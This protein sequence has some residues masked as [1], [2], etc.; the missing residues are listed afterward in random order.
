MD[1]DKFK[2]DCRPAQATFQAT[3]IPEAIVFDEFVHS[4]GLIDQDQKIAVLLES[5]TRFGE[6]FIKAYKKQQQDRQSSKILEHAESRS[7]PQDEPRSTRELVVFPF[8]M[9]IS[10]VRL[11]YQKAGEGKGDGA[12]LPTFGSKL[13]MPPDEGES[14]DTEPSLQAGMT[15]VQ[16][17]RMLAGI[18]SAIAHEGFRYVVITASDVR[19]KIFLATL[20]RQ[21]CPDVR[22]LFTS[23]EGLLSHPNFSPYLKGAL[24]AGTYPLY[25]KNQEWSFPYSQAKRRLMFSSQSQQG[26]YNAVLALLFPQDGKNFLEYGPPF[27]PPEQ[28]VRPPIWISI[29]GQHGLQPLAAIT[30]LEN[31]QEEYEKYVVPLQ[32]VQIVAEMQAKK[33]ERKPPWAFQP[34]VT[35]FWITPF[36][37]AALFAAVVVAAYATVLRRLGSGQSQQPR[38]KEG[39]SLIALF[40]PRSRRVL[41]WGQGAYVFICLTATALFFFAIAWISLIPA[42]PESN[43][44]V[45][46]RWWQWPMPLLTLAFLFLFLFL[47]IWRLILMAEKQP[48][49]RRLWLAGV[50]IVLLGAVAWW[51]FYLVLFAIYVFPLLAILALIA[52]VVISLARAPRRF[53]GPALAYCLKGLKSYWL[54]ILCSSLLVISGVYLYR[55][56]P[57]PDKYPSYTQQKAQL[58]F[59]RATDLTNGVSPVIPELFVFLGLFTWGF[60]QL[61]RLFLLDSVTVAPPFPGEDEPGFKEVRASHYEILRVLRMPQRA[62]WSGKALILWLALFFGFCRLASHFVPTVEGALYDSL[63]FFCLAVLTLFIAHAFLELLRQWKCLRRLLHEIARLP[64]AQALG[65][66]PARIRSLFG[67]FLSSERPGRH[68]HQEDRHKQRALVLDEYR[69]SRADLQTALAYTDEEM[70]NLDR[71]LAGAPGNGPESPRA[72]PLLQT[73][74]ACFRVLHKLWQNVSLG[75]EAQADAVAPAADKKEDEEQ[76]GPMGPETPAPARTVSSPTLRHWQDL[77]GEYCTLELVGYLSQFF[78]QLRNLF[79]FLTLGP[80]LLLLAITSYPVPSQQLWLLYS[81]V[82]IVT[83]AVAVI[84]I[85]VQMERDPV[86]SRISGTTP[87]RINFAKGELVMNILTY[88]LPLLGVLAATSTDLANMLHSLLD[89]IIKVLR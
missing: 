59:V 80:L 72:D 8:P 24:V 61:K 19:D 20:V 75:E 43:L 40:W 76:P 13:K 66:L 32:T 6:Q 74:R 12:F 82:I 11:G 17:E 45:D 51:K 50:G 22:L 47:L 14:R 52:L 87:Y 77:A 49:R 25:G 34:K 16:S 35:S 71:N 15:A 85:F 27:Q 56:P 46:M 84:R 63:L 18:M 89:P 5:N 23:T 33:D 10:E 60:I 58:F 68:G 79:F 62:V 88:A 53:S 81:G 73:S 78:V 3:V 31:N 21:Q 44:P 86:V 64:L 2:D 65:R 29:V 39:A 38:E 30:T 1:P 54:L 4:I 7:P 83:V 48:G 70:K 42:F 69:K 67:P 28:T 26:Y 9:H 36:L 55:H 57:L 41:C 37:V